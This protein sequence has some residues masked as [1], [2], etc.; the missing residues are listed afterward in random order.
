MLDVDRGVDIYPGGQHFLHVLPAFGVA[1]A[2]RVA[3]GQFV[4]QH[5][6]GPGVQQAIQVH[7]FKLHAPVLRAHQR[8]LRQA[9]EQGLGFGAAMG[10]HHSDQH[11][12]TLTHLGVGCL[13]HGVGLA[14]AGGRAQKH[15]EPATA[16]PRQIR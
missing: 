2:G 12:D 6:C 7:F 10:F 13:K 8:L 3:V 11:P 5:Q 9:V 4:H 15:L 14:H 1:T 16:S